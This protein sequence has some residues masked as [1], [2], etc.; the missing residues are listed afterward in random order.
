[1]LGQPYLIALALIEQ[2]GKR[3]LPL[4]GKSL[5][6]S[7]P[8]DS[9]P[10]EE[11]SELIQQLLLRVFQKSSHSPIRRAAEEDSLILIQVDI[12]SIQEEIPRLKA[13]WISTGNSTKFFSELRM[14]C[15]G[16]W[17][18]TFTKGEGINFSTLA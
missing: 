14:I 7:L 4:G 6:S 10:R 11:S 3:F 18:I 2:K 9:N 12:T 15:Q 5:K 13:E 8:A 17:R 1:M 16:L